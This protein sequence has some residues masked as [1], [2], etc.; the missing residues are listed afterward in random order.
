MIILGGNGVKD[1]RLMIGVP[2]KNHPQYIQLYLA[3]SLDDAKKYGIDIHIYDSSEGDETEDIV[4]RRIDSGYDNVFIHRYSP[5]LPPEKKIKDILVSSGYD[6]VWLCGDGIILN[7]ENVMGYV[8][9]EMENNRDL[10]IF[11]FLDNK[12]RYEV[13]ND[14]TKLIV[15]QWNSI[16]LY[17]GTIYRGDFFT[18]D[19]WNRLFPI[20]T[21]NIQLAGIFDIYTQRETNAVSVD[22]DFYTPNIFKGEATWITHGNLLRTVVDH[23]P[24]AVDNLPADYDEVKTQVSKLFSELRGMLLPRNVWWLRAYDNINVKKCFKYWKQLGKITKTNRLLFLFASLIPR[25]TACKL[26]NIFSDA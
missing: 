9:N 11:N 20:Y 21:D 22:T 14:P 24:T 3:K 10:I 13:Y 18:E 17:G 25:S 2:T 5:T 16:S 12:N 26:S 15:E 1:K 6:Y 19:D 7:I 4:K 23:I 8:L